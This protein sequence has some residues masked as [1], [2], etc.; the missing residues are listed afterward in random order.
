MAH[1]TPSF[2]RDCPL[3]VI[4]QAAHQQVIWI[5]EGWMQRVIFSLLSLDVAN[6]GSPHG[7]DVLPPEIERVIERV[8]S[9]DLIA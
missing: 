6:V 9:L 8:D 4:K 7:I 2:P 5:R 3:D 1:R